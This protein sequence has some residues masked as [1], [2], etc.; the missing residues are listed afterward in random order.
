MKIVQGL[1]YIIPYETLIF[2]HW[3]CKA[4]FGEKLIATRLRRVDDFK[5]NSKEIE[6]P[7]WQ[8]HIQRLALESDR[9]SYLEKFLNGTL[10]LR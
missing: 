3:V 2:S 6:L 1:P 7:A 4:L 9:L 10:I 5:V 8:Y